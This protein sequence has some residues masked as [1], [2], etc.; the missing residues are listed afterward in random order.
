MKLALLL[1]SLSD[2]F[3]DFPLSAMLGW[4]HMSAP[5]SHKEVFSLPVGL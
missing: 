1:K 3:M 5:S 4:A 2:G